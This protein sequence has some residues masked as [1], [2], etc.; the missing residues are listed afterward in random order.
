MFRNHMMVR[1]SSVSRHT[2]LDVTLRFL[3]RWPWTNHR[4]QAEPGVIPA[5]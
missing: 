1:D 3:A 2:V 5:S 4:V